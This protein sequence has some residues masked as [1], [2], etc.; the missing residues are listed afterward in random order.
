M[1]SWSKNYIATLCQNKRTNEKKSLSIQFL[2]TSCFALASRYGKKITP[3]KNL[4][5]LSNYHYKANKS[6]TVKIKCL[7]MK[8]SEFDKQKMRT[9]NPDISILADFQIFGSGLDKAQI[10]T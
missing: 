7:D 10:F 5:P 2:S 9:K 8:E 3:G 6:R 4:L 1:L